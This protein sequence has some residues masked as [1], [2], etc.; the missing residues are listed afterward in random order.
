MKPGLF[1]TFDVEC[2]MGGAFEDP[3]A[4]P[5][6][7]ARAV[8]GEYGGRSLGLG[9]ILEVL[10]R[11]SLKGTFFVEPFMEEQGYPGEG[12][13]ITDALAEAGQDVELHIHPCH[14]FY[15][16]HLR[17]EPYPP[18]DT[19]ADLGPRMQTA[20]F[21]EGADRL[22]SWTG[23]RPVAFRAGNMGAS[24][25]TLEALA[26]AD[27]ALD[28]SYTFP[29]AGGQCRF[30]P[31][32]PY[33]GSRRY[34]EVVEL[35]LSGFTQPRFPGLHPAK[36]LDLAGVSFAEM[37]EATL[38]IIE[39]GADAV[40]ILHPFSLLKVRNLAYDGGRPDRV[41]VR[42]FERFCRWLD[43]VR[44]TVGARTFA[45]VATALADGR[46]EPREAPPPRLGLGR[47]LMRKAVQA[48]N[49]PHWT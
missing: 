9:R 28:S 13:R 12:K 37:R 23:R 27:L 11:H 15:A 6:P 30:P 24:E 44:D 45:D 34:G 25:A 33:N 3:S 43:E 36:P 16:K 17:G 38:R 31:G 39:A 26:A 7:P 41:V 35:A 18:T 49:R 32:D 19:M 1:L 29:Y 4:L 20:L 2:S 40:M 42:R 14:S 48:W 5:V 47:A 21:A 46:D 22:A 8:W 10:G